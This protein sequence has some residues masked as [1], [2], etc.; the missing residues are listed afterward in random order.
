MYR[1]SLFVVSLLTAGVLQ[2]QTY[3]HQVLVLNEG[4]YDQTT[5]VVP[6]S[7][8]SYDP[9]LGTYQEVAV[10]TGPRFGSDVIVDGSSI[11]V[12]ADDRLYRIDADSY[13]V[14][15]EEEVQGVRK[16][17]VWNGFLLMTR[18]ELGG[19]PDYFQAR[20]KN[21]L[22]LL[23]EL[24]PDEGLNYSAEDI[25]VYGDKAYLAVNN[26][27]DWSDLQGMVGVIDLPTMSYL[28]SIDLGPEGLNPEKVMFKDGALYTFNN[29]DFTGSSVSRVSLATT[30]MEYTE[31]VSINSGCAASVLAD[32][33][34]YYLEYAQNELAR[35]DVNS[36][37]VADTLFGSPSIYG[38]VYDALNGVIYAT[39]TDFVSSGDFHVLGLDGTVLYTVAAGVA[40]GNMALDV[41]A[42]TGIAATAGTSYSIY[43]NPATDQITIR[44][45]QMEANATLDVVDATGRVVLQGAL[46]G[47][48]LVLDLR[49]LAPGL[50]ALRSA[51]AIRGR[52]IKR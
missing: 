14:L 20:D 38:L 29:T 26:A 34:I 41:R 7:L 35:F 39:A 31:P 33:H 13:A 40:A 50:Y 30:S 17:A 3:V 1:P 9:A 51:D 21:S 19:L 52:F 5:Q 4:Y 27:F 24:G 22:D 47:G 8:G 48:R 23:H 11:Y 44:A 49:A 2:A 43:P 25:E 10:F 37:S 28:T 16:L 46:V 45:E 36:A 12:A 15:A 18:G 32:D 42:A 6:V